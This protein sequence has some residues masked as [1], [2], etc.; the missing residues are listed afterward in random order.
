MILKSADIVLVQ[1]P[2]TDLIKTKQRPAM[3]LNVT[4]YSKNLRLVTIA[5]ITSQ[6]DQPQIVGDYDI[7]DWEEAG[8]LHASRLRLAKMATLENELIKKP[9]GKLSENDVKKIKKQIKTMFNYWL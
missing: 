7:V 8:L 3:V 9:L 4:P 2:F 1:F 5:M 6:I